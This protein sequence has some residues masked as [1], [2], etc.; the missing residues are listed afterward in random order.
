MN[1]MPIRKNALRPSAR[2]YRPSCS[3]AMCMYLP[4]DGP[5][6]G[7]FQ[8]SQQ[9]R[10]TS[11]NSRITKNKDQT[12]SENGD[13]ERQQEKHSLSPEAVAVSTRPDGQTC[14]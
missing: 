11:G 14:R 9:E 1:A 2:R 7:D 8:P 5:E 3:V 4:D 6:R 13:R 10:R 12:G